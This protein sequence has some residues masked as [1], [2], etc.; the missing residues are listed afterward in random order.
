MVSSA[1]LSFQ[2]IVEDCIAGQVLKERALKLLESKY[3]S[4][5]IDIKEAFGKDRQS[6]CHYVPCD[7]D[8]YIKICD[9]AERNKPMPERL[10]NDNIIQKVIDKVTATYKKNDLESG[11]VTVEVYQEV[12]QIQNW[13]RENDELTKWY[14]KCKSE[15]EG[16]PDT[17]QQK[18]NTPQPKY[19]K[20]MIEKGLLYP[21]GKRVM[22]RLKDIAIYLY[23]VV[24]ISEKFLHETFLKSNGTQYSMSTCKKALN[25]ATAK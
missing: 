12:H 8:Q 11:K 3:K 23:R 17:P 19:I 1:A 14:E 25:F 21:D 15:I 22:K 9:S 13:C 18:E 24:E 20:D 6:F 4:A 2:R 7:F 5:L 16:I 10:V